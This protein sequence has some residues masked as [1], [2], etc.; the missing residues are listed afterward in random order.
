MEQPD[1]C[2]LCQKPLEDEDESSL[3]VYRGQTNFVI[4]NRYP[5]NPGHLM[6]APYRHIA[7]PEDFTGEELDEHYRLVRRCLRV[8]RELF[9]PS[10]FNLGMNLGKVSGAGIDQH[11]HTHVVP[12][13]QGDT[14]FMPVIAGTKVISEAL[15]DTYQK[16]KNG[17]ATG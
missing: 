11:I 14:N 8:L 17:F 4:M 5:Y 15:A 13:W 1:G 10:G 2:I 3:I 9:D 16:L 12:R 7:T 6:V